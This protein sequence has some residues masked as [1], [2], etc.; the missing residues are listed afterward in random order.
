ML[1]IKKQIILSTA[2]IA[3][4]LFCGCFQNTDKKRIFPEERYIDQTIA[5]MRSLH[6]KGIKGTFAHFGDSITVT[7]AFWSPLRYM[8]KNSP[9]EMEKAFDI[10]NNY[11]RPECWSDWKGPEYGNEGTMT[12]RWAYENIDKWLAKLNPETA[13]IMFGTNDLTSISLEEYQNKTKEVVQKCLDNGTVVILTTIPPR[14]GF[15]EKSAQ[16]ADAIRQIAKQLNVYLIDYY[17]EIIKRRP[18]DWDGSLEKFNIWSGYNVP[19]LISRDGVHP[20][21]PEK[22]QNDYSEEAL[23]C[24]GYSLRN[25]LTLIKYAEVIEKCLVVR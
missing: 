15:N 7:M 18:E 1:S 2:V 5:K 20:S 25:Y 11:M 12:I 3:I 8:R 24:C 13:L 4:L 17:S 10:V 16:F 21:H 9:P 6:Y 19:T 23:N 22:Y 14:S